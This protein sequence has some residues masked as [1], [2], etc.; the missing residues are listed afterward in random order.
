[1]SIVGR[2]ED[3]RPF[4]HRHAVYVIPLRIGGG[5]R[6]KAYEAMAMAKP[7]VS[8]RIGV[9]GLPVRA[10]DHVLLADRPDDFAA[11]VARLLKDHAARNALGLRARTYVERHAS[12][13]RAGTVFADAC[14]TVARA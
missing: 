1:V 2:V 13:Q 5:T 4:V 14:R 6:I 3:I 9:E 10:G 11:A 7:V 8:T 12:W